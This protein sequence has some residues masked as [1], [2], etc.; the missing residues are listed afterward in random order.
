MST[1]SILLN[2]MLV[3]TFL[4]ITCMLL[5][6]PSWYSDK[7]SDVIVTLIVWSL[8]LLSGIASFVF[9]DILNIILSNF[10]W[11]KSMS[12]GNQLVI[13]EIPALFLTYVFA[14]FTKN[15]AIKYSLKRGWIIKLESKRRITR[16]YAKKGDK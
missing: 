11:F 3:L 4:K 13:T 9:Q 10:E 14:V 5:N 16:S 1:T 7:R 2:I 8:L 15:A 12:F 6:V